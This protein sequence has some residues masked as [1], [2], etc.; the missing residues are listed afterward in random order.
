[1]LQ[2]LHIHKI[3]Y[4]VF[5]LVSDLRQIGLTERD[6]EFDEV[7]KSVNTAL[8]PSSV[9]SDVK[10]ILDDPKVTKPEVLFNQIQS[11]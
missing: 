8:T 3:T 6:E 4:S 11:L 1:V 10:A 9:G 2:N 7:L 5:D